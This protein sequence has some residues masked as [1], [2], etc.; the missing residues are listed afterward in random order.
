MGWVPYYAYSCRIIR[1]LGVT[2]TT[3]PQAP[4]TSTTYWLRHKWRVTPWNF[5]VEFMI[6][7]YKDAG[8]FC[9]HWAPGKDWRKIIPKSQPTC[10]PH[11]CFLLPIID[12]KRENLGTTLVY[13]PLPVP[14]H[15]RYSGPI[16]MKQECM[17]VNLFFR[18]YTEQSACVRTCVAAPVCTH[19]SMHTHTYTSTYRCL[20]LADII[21]KEWEKC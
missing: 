9:Q 10:P 13:S 17:G 18:P 2:V 1:N 6:K 3:H 19:M 14:Q 11:W 8:H 16:L 15:E 7:T 20:L 5:S 12:S 21:L 4:L